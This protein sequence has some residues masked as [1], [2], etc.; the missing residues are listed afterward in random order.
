MRRRLVFLALVSALFLPLPATAQTPCEVTGTT[1]TCVQGEPRTARFDVVPMV[2]DSYRLMVNA[3]QRGPTVD[4]DG[5]T[6][7]IEVSFGAAGLSEGTYT[8]AA[9]AFNVTGVATS[10]PITLMIVAPPP[11]V[12]AP[13]TSLQLVDVIMRGLDVAGNV[14]WTE[15]FTMDGQARRVDDWR[16]LPDKSDVRTRITRQRTQ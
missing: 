8:I 7:A 11:A 5:E 16:T 1:Y 14:L 3:I 10:D 2:G 6:A 4:S 12:P 9:E 13:P 15:Q